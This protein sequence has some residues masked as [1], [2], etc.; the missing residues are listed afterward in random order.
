MDGVVATILKYR[1]WTGTF[2]GR[3]TGNRKLGTRKFPAGKWHFPRK[4]PGFVKIGQNQ[5]VPRSQEFVYT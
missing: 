5:S 4:F 3:K 1:R 2:P